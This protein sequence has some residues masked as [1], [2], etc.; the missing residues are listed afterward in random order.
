VAGARLFTIGYQG[1]TLAGFVDCLAGNGV[2]TLVDIRFSPF[3]R[4]PEFRQGPLRTAIEQAGIYYKH[5]RLLGN[6]PESRAAAQAGDMTRYRA[7]FQ[8]HLD[9][10]AVRTARAEVLELLRSGP[11]CLMCL[12]RRPEDCHRLMVAE[13]LAAEASLS[14]EH[15]HPPGPVA[16]RQPRLL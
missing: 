10:T 8:A 7:L 11:A 6:P 5:L 15:L 4:R 3:S 12:E 14:V 9:T 1:A 2:R 13:R 16:A